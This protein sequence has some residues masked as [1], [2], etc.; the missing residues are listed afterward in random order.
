MGAEVLANFALETL[1][2]ARMGEILLIFALPPLEPKTCNF[3]GRQIIA[4]TYS[5]IFFGV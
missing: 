1:G 3:A 4:R 2:A 5:L